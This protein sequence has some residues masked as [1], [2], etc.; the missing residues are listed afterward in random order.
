MLQ[1]VA[2]GVACCAALGFVLGLNGAGHR[3]RLPGETSDVSD[4]P[5]L[6][7]ADA[8]PISPD[9]I[10][11][12]EPAEPGKDDRKD[13]EKAAPARLAEAPPESAAPQPLDI[14]PTSDKV[15]DILDAASQPPPD[16]PPH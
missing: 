7:A 9:E 2:S 12:P 11:P 5:P 16:E 4:T 15:G 13:D 10:A 1:V 8:R 14:P 6:V 3:P